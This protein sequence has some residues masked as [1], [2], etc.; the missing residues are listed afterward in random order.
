MR[1][2]PGDDEWP[3]ILRRLV[4]IAEQAKA[5]VNICRQSIFRQSGTR[6][7][8]ENAFKQAI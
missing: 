4:G 8:A 1:C 7:A 2:E 6:F 3:A 5:C